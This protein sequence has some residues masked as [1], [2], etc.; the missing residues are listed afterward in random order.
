M[1]H[2]HILIYIK[3]SLRIEIIFLSDDAVF[4][5]FLYLYGVKAELDI[6]NRLLVEQCIQGN[7]DALQLFYVRFAPRMLAL[8]KRYVG[9]CEEAEDILHDGFILAFTHLSELRNAD[10]PEHWLATIMKNIALQ[11][12]KN[13][14]VT[15][16]LSEVPDVEDTPEMDDILDFDT[17]ESLIRKLPPGYQKVFR[18]AVLENKSHKEIA[19]ILGIAPNSSSSQLFHAKM[20][21][22]KLVAEYRKQAGLYSFVLLA[23]T[24]A[25]WVLIRYEA[26]NMQEATPRLSSVKINDRQI[27]ESGYGADPLHTTLASN[28]PN[29][30]ISISAPT[31]SNS[32]NTEEKYSAAELPAESDEAELKKEI[33]ATNNN[34]LSAD[35]V[36]PE[37]P[38]INSLPSPENNHEYYAYHPA[39][40]QTD[41][42]SVTIGGNIP[43]NNTSKADGLSSGNITD[44]TNGVFRPLTF[45]DYKNLSHVNHLP[46]SFALTAKKSISDRFAIETGLTYTMLRTS[47]SIAWDKSDYEIKT[48]CTWHYLGVPLR[49]NMKIFSSRRLSSYFTAGGKLDIPVYSKSYPVKNAEPGIIETGRFNS[50]ISWSVEASYG[51]SFRLNTNIDLFLDPTISYHFKHSYKVPNMWTDNALNFTLPIGLRFSW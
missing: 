27:Q 50:P 32:K 30:A 47:F 10:H 11:F 33:P 23:V 5:E 42:W 44:D 16:I 39:Q 37:C 17:L 26:G 4:G 51:I 2:R 22:R 3:E 29:T 6:G 46:I 8:I 41:G 40:K 28:T 36:E 15:T 34:V 7:K 12:L 25:V 21:M 14:D 38:D 49:L 48:R 9:N 35:T 24:I 13:Q 18:L 31:H 20:M 19:S 43:L 45:N 1:V